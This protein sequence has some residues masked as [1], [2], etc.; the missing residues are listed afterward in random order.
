MGS[1]RGE[2]W[3][4]D[5]HAYNLPPFEAWKE[6][7]KY[8]AY[9][10]GRLKKS[11]PKIEIPADDR[12][13]VKIDE[14]IKTVTTELFHPDFEWKYTKGD[15][16]TQP[17]E[18]HFYYFDEMYK[19]RNNDGSKIPSQF[20]ALPIHIGWMPRQFHNVLHAVTERPEMP[21]MDDMEEFLQSY[22]IAHS[23][24]KRLFITAKNTVE[25]A[26]MFPI[27]RSRYQTGTVKP[28]DEDDSIGEA[29]MRDFFAR[30]YKSYSDA[31]D[32]YYETERK[33]IVY[34]EH[35]GLKVT[36]PQLV[37]RKLGQVVNRKHVVIRLDAQNNNAA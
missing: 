5:Q 35:E 15:L 8:L 19:P 11:I 23:A 34:Q 9:K 32:E 29:Y 16:T 1:L 18:H 36:R 21:Q 6:P 14:F 20:R 27:L 7:E 2:F 24:F 31:I 33:E 28:K 3:N 22:L 25:A 12:G 4:E 26:Q 10:D 37:V 13:F 30:H 17:D